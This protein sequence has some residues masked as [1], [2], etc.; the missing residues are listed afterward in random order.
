MKQL[1]YIGLMFL[2]A[3]I[4][5]QI[6]M[7]QQKH[8]PL[9]IRQ[10]HGDFYVYITYG[11][12]DGL[13]YPANGMYV[14]TRKGVVLLD[15]PWDTTQFQP[16]LDSIQ[17]RHHQKVVL[18]IATHFHADRTIGLPYYATKGIATYSS[19]AT[20][21][22]C[23]AKKEGLAEHVFTKDTVFTVG[24]YRFQTFYPG[25]GHS[26]D[27]IV[28]W[29]PNDQILYG[30]CFIKSKETN[31]IGNLSDA[32]VP[33]WRTSIQKTIRQFP[34]TAYVIPGHLDGYGT[35]NLQHTA[36]LVDNYLKKNE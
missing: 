8:A 17:N 4:F 26:S 21:D 19:K 34:K 12:V 14:V 22:F 15:T 36:Q 35:D 33:A 13:L 23:K 29:F 32:N 5:C 1:Q 11:N 27:N 16:L 31:N 2:F 7:A 20:Q 9:T 24:N 30:G 10:L 6:T 3:L 18:C 28:V 25:E